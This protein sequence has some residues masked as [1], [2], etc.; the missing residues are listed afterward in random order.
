MD[1]PQRVGIVKKF[2]FIKRLIFLVGDV[3]FVL[4]PDGYHAVERRAFNNRLHLVRILRR[5]FL[6]ALALHVH[7]DRIANIIRIFF[8]DGGQAILLQKLGIMLI[9]GIWLDMQRD[10][11]AGLRLFGGRNGVSIPALRLPAIRLVRAKSAA[12][13]GD[14]V[15]HHE[16]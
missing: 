7:T 16:R 15:G 5:T 8:D 3:L 9:L 4:L 13:N 6:G 2:I 11:G 10:L 14:L 1:D 12:D